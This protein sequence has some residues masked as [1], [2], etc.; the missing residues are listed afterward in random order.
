MR[1]FVILM[2]AILLSSS[3]KKSDLNSELDVAV[4]TNK[5]KNLKS[6]QNALNIVSELR[7]MNIKRLTL[8]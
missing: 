7:D 4:I 6:M 1:F 8:I 5:V 3:C 2:S